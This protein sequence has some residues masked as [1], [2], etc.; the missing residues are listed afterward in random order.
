MI[1]E[2][3]LLNWPPKLKKKKV[4]TILNLHQKDKLVN[5]QVITMMIR[6]DQIRL[7]AVNPVS[8]AG[9]T[10]QACVFGPFISKKN[11]KQ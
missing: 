4:L 9:K 10:S 2:L 1:L 5:T 7:M 11:R 3:I 6:L 8:S